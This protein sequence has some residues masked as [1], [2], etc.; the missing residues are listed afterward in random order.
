MSNI[1]DVDS[2]GNLVM[3]GPCVCVIIVT[4]T[5]T[6]TKR[7]TW[8]ITAELKGMRPW[9]RSCPPLR[10]PPH[11]SALE[12]ESVPEE[13]SHNW[14]KNNGTQVTPFTCLSKSPCLQFSVILVNVGLSLV[15]IVLVT[16]LSVIVLLG[17]SHQFGTWEQK[18]N[19]VHT[20]D[21]IGDRKMKTGIR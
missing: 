19:S 9:S 13:W 6:H 20:D 5:Y 8:R 4:V 3:E 17:Y 10:F 2:V 11:D 18:R 21:Q 7:G 16:L 15:D 14:C 12:G 1:P